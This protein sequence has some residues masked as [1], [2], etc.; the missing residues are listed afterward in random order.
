LSRGSRQGV[1]RPEG[2]GDRLE[3]DRHGP[4]LR[5]LR[6]KVGERALDLRERGL[7]PRPRFGSAGALDLMEG[8]HRLGDGRRQVEHGSGDVRIA[9][10]GVETVGERFSSSAR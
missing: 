3:G 9:L 5:R 6:L 4:V 2:R 1:H 10:Q 8:P 7:S